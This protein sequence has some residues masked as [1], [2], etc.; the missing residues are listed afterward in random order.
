[1]TAS[2]FDLS[3][4]RSVLCL[5]GI[6]PE[7]SFFKELNLPIIAADGAADSLDELGLSPEIIIGDL[8]SVSPSIRE[9]N[10]T[11]HNPDQS[12]ND[13]QKS[14][15]Y[16]KENNLLPSIVVGINGGHL[17]HVLNNINIFLETDSLLYAPP[18]IGFVLKP[19]T[20]QKL[21][22]PL[23]T[24]ISLIGIPFA[25][26]SSTGLKWELDHLSLAFP[27]T[28]SCFNRTQQ[29]T[30]QLNVHQGSVLVLIY[31]EPAIDAGNF[32]F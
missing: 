29:S 30:I 1:M 7:V 15:S 4:Y 32:A 24:K 27:G 13:Y 21:T 9:Q 11:L 18:L 2:R 16:L 31:L 14:L 17:D 3:L 23:N 26:V 25:S 5:N 20:D 8:D 6:L 22:L 12:T 19:Q 28:N 10:K